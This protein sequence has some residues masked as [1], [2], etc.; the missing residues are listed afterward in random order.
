MNELRKLLEKYCW[1]RPLGENEES[2][3]HLCIFVNQS[4]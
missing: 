3:E 1:Y 2:L 4:A